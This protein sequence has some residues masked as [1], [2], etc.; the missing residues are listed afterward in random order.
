MRFVRLSLSM[1]LAVICVC[2]TTATASFAQTSVTLDAT[3]GTGTI[4]TNY[5]TTGGLTLNLGFFAD[6]L[7]VGG[8]GGGG[9]ATSSLRGAGGGGAGGVVT[10]TSTPLS[11][12]NYSVLVG[13]GGAGGA[14]S[15]TNASRQGKTGTSSAFGSFTATGGGGGGAGGDNSQFA[16]STGGSGG[17]AGGGGNSSQ[18]GA[19]G[20][21][22][23]TSQ[24]TSGGA[25]VNNTGSNPNGSSSNRWAGGGGGGAGSAGSKGDQAPG[26]SGNA[27][28][29]KGGAGTTSSISGASVTYAGG[30]GGGAVATAT[31]GSPDSVSGTGGAGG[32]GNGGSGDSG[33]SGANGVNGLGGGGGGA[34]SSGTGGNGGSGRVIVRYQGAS[35]GNIGGTVTTGAG[36]AAGY[37][38]HTFTTTGSANFD[39][40]AVDLGTRLGARLT[41][42]ISGTGGLTYAG[43]GTLTLAAANTYTGPTVI[44]GGTL[45][46]GA[47]G[48][49]AQSGTTLVVGGNLAGDST[50][51]GLSGGL[52]INGGNVSARNVYIANSQT[53][54]RSSTGVLTVASGTLLAAGDLGVGTVP[55]MLSNGFTWNSTGSGTFNVLSGGVVDVRGAFISGTNSGVGVNAGGT[56]KIG[57]AAFIVT[58]S[59]VAINNGTIVFDGTNTQAFSG[60]I[61][62]TGAVVKSGGLLDI[63]STLGSTGGWTI[64]SGTVRTAV[65]NIYNSSTVAN[66]GVLQFSMLTSSTFA[67]AISGAG[68]LVSASYLSGVSLTLTGSNTFTGLT[69][70]LTRSGT[71]SVGDGGT[72]GSLAGGVLLSSNALVF[73]RSDESTYGGNITG[74]G[75]LTKLGAGALTLTGSSTFTGQTTVSSGTLVLGSGNALGSSAAVVVASGATLQATQPIRIGYIDS[76][77]TVLGSENLSATLTVTNSGLIGGIANGTDSQGTFAAGIVKLSSGTSTVNAVNTYT[78][79]TWVRAGTL[80]TGVADAFAAASDLTVESGASFDRGGF[81]QT[82]ANADVNGTVGNAGEGGGLLTVTG[83]LSGSGVVNGAT[84]VNGFHAPGN[85]PG[86]QTFN[87]DLTYG[88]AAAIGWELIDNTQSNSPVV[89][90]QVVL[91]GLSDLAFSGANVLS[92]SF[93]GAGSLVN[94]NDTFWDV[95]RVW[96]VFDLASGVTTGLN[97]L[98][99]GGSLFDS[100]G[101]LLDGAT[102]GSF[103]LAQSGQDVVLQFTAVPEPSTLVLLAVGGAGVAFTLRRRKRA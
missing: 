98:S 89:Y 67:G 56:L 83:T 97:N 35:L 14:N 32:G 85:S 70:V 18:S 78:G 57:G 73:N 103:S 22:G 77:G 23:T 30:G 7:V 59:A 29:G 55:R 63:S 58:G 64:S 65:G 40:S 42:A 93:N 11:A 102:R 1:P 37:T 34:A 90:D 71:L 84:L 99:L 12:I 54:P 96:T 101:L 4:S 13:A 48:S 86:V 33:S 21:S 82:F 39:M 91:T 50:A 16:G 80:A 28:G 3:S 75:S 41:G 8:G 15:S 62:G 9:G 45:A 60:T 43:P 38:I 49:I 2:V 79:R 6:Y 61:T 25:S 51:N 92:L 24:G 100:N 52:V 27:T 69:S 36:S 46:V 19:V 26:S 95:N 53:N 87:D 76:S 31:F 88:N 81:S 20:G 47:G 44:R 74:N 5:T 10:G 66:D 68:R 72:S 94:W 17:G